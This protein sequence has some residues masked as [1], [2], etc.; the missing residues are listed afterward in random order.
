MLG[1]TADELMLNI[2]ADLSCEYFKI[3]KQLTRDM[4]KMNLYIMVTI[5]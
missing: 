2:M 4:N 3:L 5:Q 1:L